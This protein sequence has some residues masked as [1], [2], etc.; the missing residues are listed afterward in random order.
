METPGDGESRRSFFLELEKA[1]GRRSAS[2]DAPT[3]ADLKTL[4]EEL[5]ES[6]T[7]PSGAARDH[8]G[9]GGAFGTSATPESLRA[10]R[11]RSA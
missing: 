9:S 3:A 6:P 5:R 11:G 8:H 10:T 4:F 1:A 7:P 2:D